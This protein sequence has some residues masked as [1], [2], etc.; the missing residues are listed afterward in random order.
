M[1][2]LQKIK[3]LF[4]RRKPIYGAAIF[5]Q[6]SWLEKQVEEELY[7]RNKERGLHNFIK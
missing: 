1:K 3:S 6:R 5:K 7:K 2:L 4:T